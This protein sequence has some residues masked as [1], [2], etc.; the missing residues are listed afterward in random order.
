MSKPHIYNRPHTQYP[1]TALTSTNGSHALSRPPTQYPTAELD[2]FSKFTN[3]IYADNIVAASVRHVNLDT[4]ISQ[5][6]HTAYPIQDL[7][8]TLSFEEPVASILGPQLFVSYNQTLTDLAKTGLDNNLKPDLAQALGRIMTADIGGLDPSQILF[9]HVSAIGPCENV[10]LLTVPGKWYSRVSKELKEALEGILPKV[11][12]R[13][14]K[15]DR[16]HDLVLVGNPKDYN[17]EVDE[18]ITDAPSEGQG[19]APQPATLEA[20]VPRI[21]E[22]REQPCQRDLGSKTARSLPRLIARPTIN[23]ELIDP[24]LRTPRFAGRQATV[25][26]GS[27]GLPYRIPTISSYRAGSVPLPATY[28]TPAAA[29]DDFAFQTVSSRPVVL[30]PQTYSE[31]FGSEIS[32][33]NPVSLQPAAQSAIPFDPMMPRCQSC[34]SSKKGCDRMRPCGTCIKGGKT[35]DECI[36]EPS[37]SA[38]NGKYGAGSGHRI[39]RRGKRPRDGGGSSGGGSAE[40]SGQGPPKRQY[41]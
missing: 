24:R 41:A 38:I 6:G 3:K 34:V 32:T 35:A 26:P 10:I 30:R 25:S 33:P 4:Q 31:F 7:F 22:L 39:E 16:E 29:P 18:R 40:A 14:K 21:D 8:E 5:D 2:R 28:Q 1:T 36:P 11:D 12:F 15:V 9:L 17:A 19:I 23:R 37:S 20:V 13:V 27:I